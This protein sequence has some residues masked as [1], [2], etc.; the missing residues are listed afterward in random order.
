MVTMQEGAGTIASL[1]RVGGHPAL[2]FV[3]TADSWRGGRPGSDYLT[4]YA[5][6]ERWHAA[7]G[8][9]DDEALRHLAAGS[10]RAR[11]AAWRAALRLREALHRLFTAV[12]SG[13]PAPPQSLRELEAVL[14]QTMRWR[15][16]R[17]SGDRVV[18]GW[19]FVGAPPSGILGP[20]AW[21]AA[22]LLEHG[23]VDRIKACPPGDGCG[24]LFLDASKN[25]SRTWCSMKTCGNAAKVRRF[26]AR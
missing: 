15:R 2:D 3:N 4:G 5:A 23:P 12:G 20:V 6:L 9:L 18:G 7:S 1:D 17:A 26:R 11:R 8:L 14:R 13:R 21:G 25:R 10:P 16:L 22:E 19:Y 24:W